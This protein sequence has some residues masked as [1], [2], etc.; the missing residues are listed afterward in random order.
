MSVVRQVLKIGPAVTVTVEAN[1]SGESVTVRIDGGDPV[2]VPVVRSPSGAFRMEL[3]GGGRTVHALVTP[4]VVEI[5]TG[6]RVLAFERVEDSAVDT[7]EEGD[8]DVAKA[9]MPGKVVQVA[10]AAGDLVEAGDTLM[11]LEA[12]KLNN[13]VLSPRAGV[14]LSV[15]FSVGDQVGVGE[16]LVRLVD[17]EGVEGDGE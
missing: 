4:R 16:T 15:D 11:V 8:A 3:P 5:S 6:G 10:V 14:V 1:V 13:S 7:D 12:M 2:E 17:E 9:P